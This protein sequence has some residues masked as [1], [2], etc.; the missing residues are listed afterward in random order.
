MALIGSP[1]ASALKRAVEMTVPS[2]GDQSRKVQRSGESAGYPGL[3]APDR[4]LAR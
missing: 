1:R 2:R 3:R 4:N